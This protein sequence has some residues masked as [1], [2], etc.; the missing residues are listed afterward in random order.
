MFPPCL[1]IALGMMMMFAPGV[2]AGTRHTEPKGHEV[3]VARCAGCHGKDGKRNAGAAGEHPNVRS[4]LTALSKR[5]GGT[6]P[7]GRV[8][9]ILVGFVDIPAHHGSKPMPIWGGV[10]DARTN[11]ARRRASERLE[12]LTAYLESIQQQ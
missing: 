11:T 7:A 5:N 6:F 10:F 2:T 8:W 4:D 9:G 12:I 3:Y 1:T